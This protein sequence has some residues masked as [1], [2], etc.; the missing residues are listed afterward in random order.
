MLTQEGKTVH[1]A[2]RKEILVEVC[3]LDEKDKENVPT[4]AFSKS[5]P[6]RAFWVS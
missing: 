2:I 3:S 4:L 6:P 5:L 1:F